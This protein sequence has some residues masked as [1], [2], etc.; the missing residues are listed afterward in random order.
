MDIEEYAHNFSRATKRLYRKFNSFPAHQK[1]F[2]VALLVLALPLAVYLV[3]SFKLFTSRAASAQLSFSPSSTTL[4]PNS[5]LKVMA[6]TGNT[7]LVFATFTVK[8]DN[9][10]V[11]L[12]ADPQITGGLK[13]GGV[14]SR[15]QANATG[16]IG[17]TIYLCDASPRV[18]CEPKPQAPSGLF[19]L[20]SIPFE[21]VS[22]QSGTTQVTYD[23]SGGQFVDSNS[24]VFTLS[25]SNATLTLNQSGG[26][27]PTRTT[28]S[29]PRPTSSNPQAATTLSMTASST[30]VAV[31]GSL[32]VNV[33]INTNTNDVIGVD[34]EITYNSSILRMD[35]I[36][37]GSF[38]IGPDVTNKIIDNATGRAQ[39]TIVSPPSGTAKRGTGTLAVMNFT[40]VAAG[41]TN[42]DFGDAT[43]VAAVNMD[44]QNAL[45]AASGISITVGGG[46][47]SILG[48]IDGDGDVDIVDYVILFANFGKNASDPQ[49]DARADINND[50]KINILDYTYVFENFGQ[51]AGGNTPTPTST[52][53][54]PTATPVATVTTVA[55]ATPTTTS[56][57]P[58][59]PAGELPVSEQI[60]QFSALPANVQSIVNQRHPTRTI[61]EVKRETYSN[62]AVAYA[63]ELIINGSQWDI[64]ILPDGTVIRDEQEITP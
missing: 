47:S 29:T 44:G 42:V 12:S 30:S 35:D 7:Q 10:K 56:S 15:D 20:I 51:G 55:T 26:N 46:G 37:A 40:G 21:A 2:L 22:G 45:N 63:I 32:P 41:T 43:I 60:I 19:E 6:N 59:P 62:G 33:Q 9:T 34:L 52:Q 57:S 14:S 13:A 49:A 24:Q 54:N 39:I 53:N 5:T 18:P 4:P 31:G 8:F 16:T 23:L 36:T 50:G 61:Q 17:A 38:F 1:V 25:S 28:T 27:T 64:E 11:R 48:D 3:G 58:R